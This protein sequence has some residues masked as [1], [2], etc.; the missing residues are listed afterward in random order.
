MRSGSMLPNPLTCN[1]DLLRQSLDERLSEQHEEALARHLV[2]CES[3]R[4]KLERLAGGDDEWMQVSAAL[5]REANSTPS[6]PRSRLDHVSAENDAADSAIDFAVDFLEPAQSADAVGRLGDIDILETIG[7]GGMGIVFKG[8]Q[9]ELKRLVAVK[10]L[11]PH[12]ATS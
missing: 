8:Y 7:R 10:V 11:G 4:R 9:A 12:L 2:E 6:P 1:R 3:C 5:K